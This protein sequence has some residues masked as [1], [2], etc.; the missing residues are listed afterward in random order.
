MKKI[1]QIIK[2][3]F[4]PFLQK[5]I[6]FS[7]AK[8]FQNKFVYGPRMKH[9][10]IT[11]SKT[12]LFNA[13]FFEVRTRCNS[14]CSF[15]SASVQNEIRKDE[16]MSFDLY[17]KVIDELKSLNFSGKIAYHVNNEPL[18]FPQLPEFIEYARKNL[19]GAWLQILTNG[20]ALTFEKAQ[21]LLEKGINEL[22]I[23]RYGDNLSAELPKVIGDIRNNLLPKFYKPEQIKPGFGPDRGNPVFR[24][25]VFRRDVNEILTTRAGNAPNKTEKS[26]MP[27]GFCE[28]PFTQFNITA[29]GR[30]SKCCA[31]FHFSE[32]MGNVNN[33]SLMEIWNGKEF[34]KVRSYLR[35]N[36]REAMET[37]AKCDYFGCRKFYPKFLKIF[38]YLTR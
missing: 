28:H 16:S 25:N 8:F 35:N 26:R 15:C 31:D 3:S 23:N 34:N 33:Q 29:D 38:Y 2:K 32:V 12:P 11:E 1:K 5:L 21:T 13:I 10:G 24:F 20:R 7:V 9:L 14:N 17:K 22:S 37:C 30:V 27:R 4:I 6:P 36:N 19:P 18:I